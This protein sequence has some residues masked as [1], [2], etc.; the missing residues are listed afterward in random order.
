METQTLSPLLLRKFGFTLSFV[1]MGLFG[2]VLPLLLN[3]P[4]PLWPWVL[5][6]L[7]IVPSIVWPK[8]LQYVY[9]PWMKV[10]HILGWINTRIILGVIFFVLITPIGIL[11]RLMG[12][13]AMARAYDKNSES[14]RKIP[15][16]VAISHMERPF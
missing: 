12:K 15:P 5:A 8:C 11:M 7:F 3:K 9:T 10:G 4:H 1:F 6:G 16:P 13:D 2:L 14:Y